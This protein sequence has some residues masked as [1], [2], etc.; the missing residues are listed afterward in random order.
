M[1][2]TVADEL[3]M[4]GVEGESQLNALAAREAGGLPTL[5]NISNE[6]KGWLRAAMH[7]SDACK[8]GFARRA[9][10]RNP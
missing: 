8:R 4:R 1:H 6:G 9:P 10:G 2:G 7:A 5:G 3:G